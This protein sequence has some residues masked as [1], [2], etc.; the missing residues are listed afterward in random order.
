MHSRRE[1]IECCFRILMTAARVNPSESLTF[2]HVNE[3]SPMDRF[4]DFLASGISI[5]RYRTSGETSFRPDYSGPCRKQT[6]LIALSRSTWIPMHTPGGFFFIFPVSIFR[7]PNWGPMQTTRKTAK[8]PIL[9]V[10]YK[11]YGWSLQSAA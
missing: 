4:S 6:A 5:C 11:F 1:E 10:R 7:T 8:R 3:K 2:C 9:F